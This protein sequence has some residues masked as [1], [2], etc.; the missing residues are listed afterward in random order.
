MWLTP[1][2][3]L[4]AL[5]NLVKVREYILRD[6]VHQGEFFSPAQVRQFDDNARNRGLELWRQL[7][8]A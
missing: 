3:E 4:L 2:A 5:P 7:M 1:G 6:G 8:M